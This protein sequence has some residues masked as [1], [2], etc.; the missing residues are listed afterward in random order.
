VS[1]HDCQKCFYCDTALSPRHE[2][3]HFPIPARNGGRHTVPA[4]INCHD[5]KD[6]V[7]LDDWSLSAVEDA[8]GGMSPAAR[9][10]MGKGYAMMSDLRADREYRAS[11]AESV[12]VLPGDLSL[13]AAQI[14]RC[15]GMPER[16]AWMLDEE[17]YDQ[18]RGDE[19]LL[20]GAEEMRLW[21]ALRGFI[22][23]TAA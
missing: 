12:G 18:Q 11:L 1:C 21:E 15:Q 9:I 10:F 23:E 13:I 17:I 20:R 22:M 3:D 4:C 6:R 5:M 14:V 19:A 7:P 2:H 16:V 8:W